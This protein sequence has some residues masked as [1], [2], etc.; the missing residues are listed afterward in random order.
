MITYDELIKENNLLYIKSEFELRAM[1]MFAPRQ[2][3]ATIGQI[4]ECELK[5]LLYAIL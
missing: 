4:L 5:P 3:P 2:I 1:I